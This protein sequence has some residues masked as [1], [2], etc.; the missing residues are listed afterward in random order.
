MPRNILGKF[1]RSQAPVIT[2]LNSTLAQ[3]AQVLKDVN[4]TMVTKQGFAGHHN[5]LRLSL[6]PFIHASQFTPSTAQDTMGSNVVMS[7]ANYYLLLGQISL[8]C[9]WRS[10][11]PEHGADEESLLA[12]RWDFDPASWVSY[13]GIAIRARLLVQFG[14]YSRPRITPSLTFRVYVSYSHPVWECIREGD[15]MAVQRHLSNGSVGVNDAT[16]WGW[17]LLKEVG[18]RL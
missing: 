1:C 10:R 17:T 14:E 9:G 12:G 8:S 6:K 4:T 16:L 2:A 5:M 3:A 13:Q 11:E 15:L 18:S 7:Y